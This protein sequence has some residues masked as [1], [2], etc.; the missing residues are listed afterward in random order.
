MS[1]EEPYSDAIC[2]RLDVII[3]LLM[4]CQDKGDE[5]SVKSRIEKLS[6]LGMSNEEIANI[7]NKNKNHVNKEL[8]VLRKEGKIDD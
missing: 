2:R 5:S 3:N 8:S 1:M 6:N 4:E 7:L